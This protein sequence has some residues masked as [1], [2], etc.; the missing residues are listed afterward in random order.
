MIHKNLKK[1]S[2]SSH[3]KK[4]DVSHLWG[5]LRIS[6]SPFFSRSF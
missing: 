6:P 5:M 3:F 2:Q 4:I 1:F